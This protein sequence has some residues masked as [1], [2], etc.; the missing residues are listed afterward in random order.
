MSRKINVDSVDLD[1][2]T[3][4][5]KFRCMPRKSNVDRVDWGGRNSKFEIEVYVS[6]N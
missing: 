1:G 2:R 3:Q 5:S 6:K 4:K